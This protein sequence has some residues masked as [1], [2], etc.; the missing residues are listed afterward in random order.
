MHLFVSIFRLLCIMHGGIWAMVMHGHQ[1]LHSISALA[2]N[3]DDD[4]DDDDIALSS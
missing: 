3:D 2:P 1:T 4:D